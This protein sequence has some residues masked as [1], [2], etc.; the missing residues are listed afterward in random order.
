MRSWKWIAPVVIAI[1][2]VFAVNIATPK[3]AE[4]IIDEIVAA[5]CNGKDSLESPGQVRD[6][7]SFARALQATGF[8]ESV[9]FSPGPGK[10][11]L[12]INFNPDVPNSKF[13]SAGFDLT[14]PDGEAPGVDLILSPLI[15]PDPNFP[16]HAHC[17]NL[18][19]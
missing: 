11:S 7:N 9:V 18:T 19:P 12:T 14:I 17:N 5:L 3:P 6:G 16:A 10:P 2:I 13:I 8:I 1:A 4:A 15:I